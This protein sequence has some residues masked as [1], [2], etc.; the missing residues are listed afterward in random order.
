MHVTGT[1]VNNKVTPLNTTSGSKPS[2]VTTLINKI[3]GSHLYLGIAGGIL[4]FILLC[5]ICAVRK[6]QIE[7][8]STRAPKLSADHVHPYRPTAKP[9]FQELTETSSPTRGRKH[10]KHG[11]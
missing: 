11:R 5:C 10:N 7:T 6:G 2:P 4:A 9:G 1:R 3:L 8:A